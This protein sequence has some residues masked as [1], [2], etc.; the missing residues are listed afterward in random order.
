MRMMKWV[1]L[2]A[3]AL[4]GCSSRIALKPEQL[5][6]QQ[7]VYVKLQ[8]GQSVSGDIES[9]DSENLVIRDQ[10]GQAWQARRSQITELSGP[11]PIRDS[12]GRIISE[13]EIRQYKTSYN[14]RLFTISGGLLSLGSSFFL[15]SMLSRAAGE[16]NRDAIILGGTA[17]GTTAGT[18]LFYRMG[19]RK[20]RTV[21]IREIKYNRSL[22]KGAGDVTNQDKEKSKID[23]ELE[24]IRRERAQQDAE[25]EQ[26][27]S[28]IKENQKK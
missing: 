22:E 10:R 17:L 27:K 13:K 19:A 11:E 20:D 25:I 12:D 21:A 7:T 15:S 4:S 6:P 3:V 9:V 28:K 14:A 2:V 23:A 24:R 8:S 16:E 5:T 1:A 18:W 26:L